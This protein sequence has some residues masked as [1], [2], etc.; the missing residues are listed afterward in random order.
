ML[1]DNFS[2]QDVAG[3]WQLQTHGEHMTVAWGRGIYDSKLEVEIFLCQ[4]LE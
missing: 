4:I 3:S 2:L 1:W